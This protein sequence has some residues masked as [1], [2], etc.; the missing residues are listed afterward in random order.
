MAIKCFLM[1]LFMAYS[2]RIEPLKGPCKKAEV[3]TG[4]SFSALMCQVI[5]T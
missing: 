2:C 3:G 1:T 4:R 5:G